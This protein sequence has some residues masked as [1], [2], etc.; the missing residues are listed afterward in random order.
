MTMDGLAPRGGVPGFN[1]LPWRQHEFRR[2]RWRR[3]LEWLAAALLGCA[4]AAAL[5]G[6]QVWQ[7][8]DIDAERRSIEQ[9]LAQL[10]IP[11]AEQQRLV[12]EAAEQRTRVMAAQR[13]AKP[14][15]QFL[16]LLDGLTHSGVDGIALQQVVQRPN[17]TQLQA[18]VSGEAAI[19]TWL[20]RLRTMPG[21]Q[22]VSMRELKRTPAS[23][24]RAQS[25][26]EE[27]LQL[28]ALLAWAEGPAG[29]TRTQATPALRNGDANARRTR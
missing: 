7:R 13:Q 15:A 22:S 12:R 6:W 2:L 17:E 4:C 14:L 3:A 26:R 16:A 10:R 21:V 19:A 18:M 11:L 29:G 25:Q 5:A 23:G 9:S 1:L 27:P 24:A 8:A 20:A 28:T